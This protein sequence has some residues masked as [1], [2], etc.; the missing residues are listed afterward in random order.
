ML[1]AVVASQACLWMAEAT[2]GADDAL[3]SIQTALSWLHVSSG[4][5][6]RPMVRAADVTALA[7]AGRFPAEPHFSKLLAAT[8]LEA[9]LDAKTLASAVSRFLATAVSIED[10]APVQDAVFSSIALGPSVYGNVPPLV[11]DQLES[12]TCL[13]ALNNDYVASRGYMQACCRTVGATMTL[14]IAAQVDATEVAGTADYTTYPIATGVTL[15][16]MPSHYIDALSAGTVWQRAETTTEL[17][18]AIEL[19]SRAILAAGGGGTVPHFRVGSE[20]L[21]A[22]R[23]EQAS[24]TGPFAGVTI[25]K[26]AQALVATASANASPLR[27][28][29]AVN[30]AQVRRDRDGAV[31]MRAHITGGHGALRL[32]YWLLPDGSVEFSTVRNKFDVQIDE[33]T[34][35]GPRRW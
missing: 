23:R 11:Q 25:T 27:T 16:G 9:V 5:I 2:D 21:V 34:A 19:R 30:A 20:F 18:I 26:C 10:E 3:R 32:M 29:A 15:L 12:S 35:L 6:E 8:G 31:A 14:S 28:S 13:V 1:P 7:G 4:A 24:G 17:E 33:G 22:L